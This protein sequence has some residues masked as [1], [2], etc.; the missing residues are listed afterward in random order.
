MYAEARNRRIENRSETE[1]ECNNRR[2]H[3][4]F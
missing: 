2:F 4:D 3:L 1:I